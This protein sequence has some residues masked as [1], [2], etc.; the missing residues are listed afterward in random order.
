MEVFEV[1]R[2]QRPSTG[3]LVGVD[4]RTKSDGVLEDFGER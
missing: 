4:E 3:F 2:G 1:G